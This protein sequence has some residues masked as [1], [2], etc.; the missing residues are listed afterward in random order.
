MTS[1]CAL[2]QQGNKTLGLIT[3]IMEYFNNYVPQYDSAS[4]SMI[5]D[6]G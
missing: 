5:Q 4:M 6:T 3:L 2:I 1:V